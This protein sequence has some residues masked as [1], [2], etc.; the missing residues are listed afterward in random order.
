MED[1]IKLSKA[2]LLQIREKGFTSVLLD[3]NTVI[4]V[5]IKDLLFKKEE[6]EKFI[7]ASRGQ[8]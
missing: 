8:D 6:V 1:L 2:Q 3:D 4:T 7:K 5:R